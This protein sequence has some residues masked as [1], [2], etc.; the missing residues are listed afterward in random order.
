MVRAQKA[1]FCAR[2]VFADQLPIFFSHIQ[3]YFK[4]DMLVFALFL[5]VL[6]LRE[7]LSAG[8]SYSLQGSG[9]LYG[10]GGAHHVSSAGALLKLIRG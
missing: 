8:S 1:M 9:L 10:G 7:R 6:S 2:G 5:I 4:C 3:T